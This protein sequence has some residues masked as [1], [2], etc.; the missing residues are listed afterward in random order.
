MAL[1]GKP[2][3]RSGTAEFMS[4]P[5]PCLQEIARQTHQFIGLCLNF[6]QAA[7]KPAQDA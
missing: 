2:E 7:S 1:M 6:S 5:A 4:D 3:L